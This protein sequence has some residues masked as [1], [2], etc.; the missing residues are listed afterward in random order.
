MKNIVV[1][2]AYR[3]RGIGTAV[4]SA[5]GTL[6]AAMGCEAAGCFGIKDETG[7]RIY[8]RAGYRVVTRQTEWIKP[9]ERE[10]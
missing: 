2:P 5:F 10:R 8:R 6:A 3:R 4:A 7:A 1:D 9:L